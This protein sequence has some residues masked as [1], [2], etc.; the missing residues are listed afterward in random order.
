MLSPHRLGAGS[1]AGEYY[2]AD[3][4]REARPDRRDDYYARDGGGV[5]WTT[6]QTVVRHDAAIDQ[7]SFRDLCAGNDPHRQ[8]L[9]SWR[10][11]D[12]LGRR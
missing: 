9:D 4:K 2:T 5:W 1:L 6:G 11:R 7:A 3:S 10:G 12:A 8:C